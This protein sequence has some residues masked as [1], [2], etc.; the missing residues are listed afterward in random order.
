MAGCSSCFYGKETFNVDVVGSVVYCR[1]KKKGVI[2]ELFHQCPLH[3]DAGKPRRVAK[4]VFLGEDLP[5]DN[6]FDEMKRLEHLLRKANRENIKLLG[7]ISKMRGA[8]GMA[9]RAADKVLGAE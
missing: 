4:R 1:K 5:R 9:T 8:A 6:P 3:S 7:I 2:P